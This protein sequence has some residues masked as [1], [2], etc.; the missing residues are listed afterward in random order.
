MEQD[1]QTVIVVFYSYWLGGLLGAFV[2]C[3]CAILASR[4]LYDWLKFKR[5]Q[6]RRNK[7][8]RQELG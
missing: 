7:K 1:T 8:L 5:R 6:Y 4:A 3:L 2:G